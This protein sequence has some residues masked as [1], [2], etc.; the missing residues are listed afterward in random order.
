MLLSALLAAAA[1]IAVPVTI[2]Q[3]ATQPPAP[4]PSHTP[5]QPRTPLQ[6]D[7]R[8]LRTLRGELADWQGRPIAGATL[9][10]RP[11]QHYSAAPEKLPAVTIQTGADGTFVVPL[12]KAN[13]LCV[14]FT[15]EGKR[16]ERRW[17]VLLDRAALKGLPADQREITFVSPHTKEAQLARMSLA[18]R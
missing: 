2:V 15:A 11:A 12:G 3:N 17:F 13:A 6:T 18:E 4:V 10:V 8:S 9:V 5:L 7:T 1:V 14:D 16:P